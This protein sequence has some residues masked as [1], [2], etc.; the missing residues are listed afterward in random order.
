MKRSFGVKL[1]HRV[2]PHHKFENLIDNV[3]SIRTSPLPSSAIIRGIID[4]SLNEVKSTQSSNSNPI[5]FPRPTNIWNLDPK[6]E[7]DLE[8][9]AEKITKTFMSLG[10]YTESSGN[11]YMRERICDALFVRDNI[12]QTK[13]KIKLV[14]GLTVGI[15]YLFN[16]FINDNKCGVLSPRPNYPYYENYVKHA[17]GTV[18]NFDFDWKNIY[19]TI[20]NLESSVKNANSQSIIPRILLMSNPNHPTG[21]V[22]K[23][24][25]IRAII[26]FAYRNN[27]L[28]LV[29][30]SFQDVVLGDSKFTSFRKIL[31]T[32][33]NPDIRDSVELVSMYSCSRGVFQEP[34]LRGGFLEFNNIDDKVFAMFDK[35]LSMMLC[36]N[37][38]GQL[39]TGLHFYLH[40]LDTEL[41]PETNQVFMTEY[42]RNKNFMIEKRKSLLEKLESIPELEIYESDGSYY[43]WCKLNFGDDF[44]IRNRLSDKA[45]TNFYTNEV[46]KECGIKAYSGSQFL[47]P[48]Y[49]R[50]SVIDNHD[51]ESYH[52]LADLHKKMISQGLGGYT[53]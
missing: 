7:R 31:K 32:H 41:M 11:Y 36:P 25:E 48:G 6:I 51:D 5:N 40:K 28:I 53:I 46:E 9:Y 14:N 29:D 30:E 2:F 1:A 3:S 42:N 21:K 24:H 33:Q 37:T 15:R 49:I 44:L 50:L 27:I 18:V 22:F 35:F 43:I 10:A 23:P 45:F 20:D 13:D 12:Q 4:L 34:A 38:V 16:A 8:R 47:K 52:K 26:E 17:E 19:N 39:V